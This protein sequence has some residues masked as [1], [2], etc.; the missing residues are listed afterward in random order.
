MPKI[1]KKRVG[2][3]IDMTPMVDVAMLLLTFFMMTTQ[4]RPEEATAIDLPASNAP[5]K[6]PETDIMVVTVNK[7]G[8]VFLGVDSQVLRAQLFGEANK[9]RPSMEVDRKSLHDLLIQARISNPKLRT[10]VKGDKEA[11]YGPLE[12]IL[13]ILRQ[14]KI[15][16]FNL[17]TELEKA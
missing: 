13:D 15:T 5:F 16:R 8:R 3:R 17:V 10:L 1:K 12:D 7:E 6:M 2:F 9:L 11:P 4:F 14:V